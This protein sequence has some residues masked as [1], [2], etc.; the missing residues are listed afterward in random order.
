[1]QIKYFIA[2]F[3]F[4]SF[5]VHAQ[6]NA[7]EEKILDT[8]CKLKEVKQRAIYIEKVTNDTRHLSIVVFDTPSKGAQYYWVKAWEDNGI[9]YYTHFNFFVYLNPFEIKF[10][11]TMDGKVISLKEWRRQL[12]KKKS[13]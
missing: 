13:N 11:D 10:Y 9:S 8:I 2:W 1:M 3:I 7:I 6:N 12:K 5:P 4:L